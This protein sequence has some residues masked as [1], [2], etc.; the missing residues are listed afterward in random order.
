MVQR[1][2]FCLA[3]VGMLVACAHPKLPKNAGNIN[4][5]NDYGS[6]Y[7]CSGRPYW[8][9]SV[10]GIINS[11]EGID[12]GQ[13]P[14]TKVISATYGEV[15]DVGYYDC[16]GGIASVLTDIEDVNPETKTK[17]RLYARYIHI[18]INEQ[19]RNGQKVVP[20]DLIGTVAHHTDIKDCVGSVSHLHYELIFSYF[21][22]KNHVNPHRYWVDGPEKATCFS[23]ALTVP[24]GR[25]TLPITCE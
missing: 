3:T 24:V 23:K 19:L 9:N 22:H 18:K 4:I 12:F 11:H 13:T 10:R 16:G 2:I 15:V 21:P 25:A 7:G 5:C 17:Q 6:A 20:G 1:L 14:G 8:L